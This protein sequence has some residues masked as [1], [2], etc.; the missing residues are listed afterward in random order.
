M[1][2]LTTTLDILQTPVLLLLFCII[3]I[4]LIL[5]IIHHNLTHEQRENDDSETKE[6]LEIELEKHDD[7]FTIHILSDTDG[8]DKHIEN[9]DFETIKSIVNASMDAFETNNA[10]RK[11]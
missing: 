4:V 8:V 1:K 3:L 2:E 6:W 5:G 11:D 7:T 9:V 10:S